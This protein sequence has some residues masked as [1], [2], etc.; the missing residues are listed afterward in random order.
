MQMVAVRSQGLLTSTAKG[1]K[2]LYVLPWPKTGGSFRQ[3]G[4]EPT[5][6]L[7]AQLNPLGVRSLQFANG[8]A[9]HKPWDWQTTEKVGF[10]LVHDMGMH[11]IWAGGI[12]A[13]L[14]RFLHLYPLLTSSA[15]KGEPTAFWWLEHPKWTHSHPASQRSGGASENSL[16][17]DG[18]QA[19]ELLAGAL[20]LRLQ[21]KQANSVA[22]LQ[23]I[24]YRTGPKR[25]SRF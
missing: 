12:P 25:A 7:H 3:Q 23:D 20:L 22:V 9:S 11:S 18:S 4:K 8:S 13:D 19:I 10:G 14:L 24:M 17:W 1:Y 5:W 6:Y 16:G 2:S 15:P 21:K